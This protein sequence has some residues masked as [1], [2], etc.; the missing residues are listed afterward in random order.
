MLKRVLV[1]TC[2]SF[3]AILLL[4]A[5]FGES[6]LAPAVTGQVVFQVFPMSLS[7]ALLMAALEKLEERLDITSLLADT[8]LRVLI[9]YSVVFLEGC[10]FGMFPF[11]WHTL[12]IIS[13]VLLLVFVITYLIA[14]LVC[15]EY[16]DNINRAIRRMK[17]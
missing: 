1:L 17:S 15:R 3:T 12:W 14:Y 13:P 5:L 4:F 2:S 6:E 9:C 7:I 8:L 16:A 11:A 10:L